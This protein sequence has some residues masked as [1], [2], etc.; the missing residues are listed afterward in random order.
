MNKNVQAGLVDAICLAEAL[1]TLIRIDI[2]NDD[3]TVAGLLGGT[4]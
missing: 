4:L 2:D 1:H 3:R